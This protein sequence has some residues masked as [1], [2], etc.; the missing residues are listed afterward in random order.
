MNRRRLRVSH[1]WLAI[2]PVATVLAGCTAAHSAST[3][4]TPQASLVLAPG[5]SAP[6][7]AVRWCGSDEVAIGSVWWTGATTEMGGG[8]TLLDVSPTDVVIVAG[9]VARP[10]GPG[11]IQ[12]PQAGRPAD[13]A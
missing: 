13:S 5:P 11:S 2:V 12:P 1:L 10:S 3:Q 7:V 6:P 4:P 9:V 8:F